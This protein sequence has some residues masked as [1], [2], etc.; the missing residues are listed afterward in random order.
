[1]G[2]LKLGARPQVGSHICE[3]L[4]SERLRRPSVVLAVVWGILE[5]AAV[6]E[7]GETDAEGIAS[8]WK[9]WAL[10]AKILAPGP[11]QS[12]SAEDICLQIL[13]I[14]HVPDSLAAW[15]FREWPPLAL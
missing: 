7:S 5:G 1:M 4:L 11:R 14:F 9:T 6:G 13:G 3:W 15:H 2:R 8:E 10:T 12:C